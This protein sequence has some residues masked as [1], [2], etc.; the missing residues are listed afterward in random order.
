MVNVGRYTSP[1]DPMG[2]KISKI[3]SPPKTTCLL[4]VLDFTTTSDFSAEG[5]AT[6]PTP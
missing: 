3:Q 2:K 4:E 5:I 1:M 6:D